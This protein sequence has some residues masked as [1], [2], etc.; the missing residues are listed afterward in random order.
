MSSSI[1]SHLWSSP[2]KYACV[3]L[4]LDPANEQP[5]QNMGVL[6]SLIILPIQAIYDRR[7][8]KKAEKIALNYTATDTAPSQSQSRRPD[9]Q[10][11]PELVSAPPELIPGQQQQRAE[12][13][14]P[15]L[16]AARAGYPAPT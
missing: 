16:G 6:I 9:T 13:S 14:N 4:H 11:Q 3:N 10:P 7:K 5:L 15:T 8:K 12:E 2:R 1:P